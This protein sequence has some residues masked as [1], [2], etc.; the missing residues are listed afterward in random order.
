M[1][2]QS[3]SQETHNDAASA[4]AAESA[5]LESGRNAAPPLEPTD[6]AHR[7]FVNLAAT[8]MLL[9]IAMAVV[10]TVHAIE[11]HEKLQRCLS[12]GRRD[13]VDLNIPPQPG[14]YQPSR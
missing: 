7:H 5:T 10:W 9:L 2:S 8:A 12:S 3:P 4:R 14:I 6:Y 13:C 1:A 11:E